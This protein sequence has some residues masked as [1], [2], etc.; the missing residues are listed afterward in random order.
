MWGFFC[1]SCKHHSSHREDI[2]RMNALSYASRYKDLDK[3]EELASKAYEEAEKHGYKYGITD[4]LC[5]RAFCYIARMHYAQADSLLKL[6]AEYAPDNISRL[7]TEVLFMRICQRRSL[8][9]E[10][11]LHK[12]RAEKLIGHIHNNFS[13]LSEKQLERYTYLRSEY[14]I[15]LSAYLYYVGHADE[16]SDAFYAIT[17]DNDISLQ[18]DTAQWLNYLYN[19]GSG[20]IVKKST[21]EETAHAEFGYLMYCYILASHYGYIYWEAQ[22]TQALSEHLNDMSTL[23]MLRKTDAASLRYL[24]NAGMPD[25]LLSI[26]LAQHSLELFT[27]YGDVYQTAAAWR[28]LAE[29]YMRIG[30]NE[31]MLSSLMSSLNDSLIMQAPN[32]VASINEKL[33]IAYSSLNDKQS[34]DYCRNR[35][36]DM[37][38]ST[39]QDRQFEARAEDLH[40]SVVYAQMLVMIAFALF[41]VMLLVLGFLLWRRKSKKYLE[42]TA[43]LEERL[44]ELE[45]ELSMCRLN[46]SDSKRLNLEQHAK[47]SLVQNILPIIDRMVHAATRQHDEASREYISELCD[48]IQE[49]NAL[50]TR[51]VQLRRGD[52]K[53]KVESFPLQELFDVIKMGQVSFTKAGITLIVEDTDIVLKADKALT[54]FLLNTLL[55]NARKHA[56]ENGK[57]ILSAKRSDDGY[58]DISVADD[59]EGMTSEQVAHVFDYQ[60]IDNSEENLKQQ[61]S[62]GFGLLNC[63]GIINRYRKTSSLFA[64]AD[65]TVESE[66]GRGTTFTFRLPYIV[67]MIVLIMTL[68]FASQP[69]MGILK[70]RASVNVNFAKKQNLPESAR[71]ASAYCDS[72]Y[73]CNV[74]ERFEET[75]CYADSCLKYVNQYYLTLNPNATDTL[76]AMNG[77]AEMAWYKRSVPMDYDLILSLRNEVA[78]AALALHE[79]DIYNANN[80][81]YTSLY[82]EC[83]A[84]STL[85]TYCKD[86]E[87]YETISN[88]ML[89]ALVLLIIGVIVIIYLFYFR[90]IRRRK[91]DLNNSIEELESKLLVLKSER[92]RLYVANS[93]I[94]NALSTI[95]HE[96]MYYPARISNLI[97]EGS[98]EDISEIIVF[99]RL[100]YGILSSQCQKMQ[101]ENAYQPHAFKVSDMMDACSK[102]AEMSAL[103]DIADRYVLGN[104]ELTAYLFLLLKRKNK[105]KVIV[106]SYAYSNDYRYIHLCVDC[107]NL[108]YTRQD[109]VELFMSSSKDVDFLVMKQIMREVGEM[110]HRYGAGITL[111]DAEQGIAFTITLPLKA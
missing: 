6:A 94:D 69:M 86:M 99:Y 78:V 9:K 22:S 21:K 84:D 4:A 56:G 96:T 20:G 71:L 7:S 49:S 72:M 90:D 87:K 42:H 108:P 55:D 41:I 5:N 100:L 109:A 46:I 62:H 98:D 97:A 92:D 54:L 52:I 16:S 101:S 65:I 57:V 104:N 14:G 82:R 38:D 26:S 67:K 47:L 32:I 18:R 68:S 63:R 29:N 40:D 106:R 76:V 95:K 37:Q 13:S 17:E 31:A 35:Y 39:R 75:L 15:I 88:L 74:T 81:I 91:N 33:C 51:W 27:R 58:A 111:T 45:D 59:G 50:L 10:F 34:S 110:T 53:L 12:F 3:T 8:N 30:D 105:E 77:D 44:E 102:S 19:I 24:N 73:S 48:N 107:E 60:S 1:S 70:K 23:Q 61:K 80:A 79:W 64:Q 66:K 28:T 83:S 93:I 36:L 103:T 85:N 25:S 2:D 89:F 11:Y 43:H